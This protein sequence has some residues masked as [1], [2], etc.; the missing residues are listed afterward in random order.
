[1]IRLSKQKKHKYD[2]Y[3]YGHH[4]SEHKHRRKRNPRLRWLDRVLFALVILLPLTGFV[5]WLVD[6]P[7]STALLG[8]YSA[9]AQI[10]AGLLFL[11]LTALG[12]GGFG[13][14]GYFFTHT[15]GK[16][17]MTTDEAK[18]NTYLFGGFMVIIGVLLALLTF[19]FG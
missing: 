3:E 17:W 5:M 12:V 8:Y 14:V 9:A 18:G 19:K 6:V 11:T 1:M 10:I 7:I 15:R 2:E 4:H 16:R 13:K